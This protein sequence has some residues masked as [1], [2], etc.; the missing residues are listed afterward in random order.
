M[1]CFLT[2]GE[3]WLLGFLLVLLLAFLRVWGKN[4]KLKAQAKG[5]APMDRHPQDRIR[6]KNE[7][8]AQAS[9]S[10][11]P[12]NNPLDWLQPGEIALDSKRENIIAV[13]V[14]KEPTMPDNKEKKSLLDVTMPH[15]KAGLFALSM[16]SVWFLFAAWYDNLN[17]YTPPADELG[18]FKILYLK[19]VIGAVLPLIS[20]VGTALGLLFMLSP[21]YYIYLNGWLHTDYD[22]YADLRNL[23]D[24]SAYRRVLVFAALFGLLLIVSLWVLLH[25]SPQ[26]LTL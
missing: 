26:E 2:T 25:S 19:K 7:E 9:K 21:R 15:W 4:D 10:E 23:G 13:G 20:A 5:L 22:F 24:S 8:A 16:V 12:A 1:F 11:I 17:H 14:M 18:D 6:M 3:G